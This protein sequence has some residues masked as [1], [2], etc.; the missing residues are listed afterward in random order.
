MTQVTY[1]EEADVLYVELDA[2][3]SARQQSLGDL[4]I[5]DYAADGTVI[6]VEFIS[7][8]GGVELHDVPFADRIAAAIEDSGLSI[9]VFA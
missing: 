5:V 4:R 2:T 3:A 9:R 1:D 6:G 7:A 8:S